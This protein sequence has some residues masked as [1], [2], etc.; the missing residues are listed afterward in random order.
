[1]A[2]RWLDSHMLDVLKGAATALPLRVLG[3]G[4]GFALNL[5]LARLLGADDV[6]IYYLALTVSTMASAVATLGLGNVLVRYTAAEAESGDYVALKA[7]ARIGTRTSL[8]CA[9]ALTVLVATAAPWICEYILGKPELTRPLQWMALTIVPQTQMRLHA[10]LLRGLKKIALSQMLRNVDVP[11]LT[12]VFIALLGGT[13]GATGAVWSFVTANLIAAVMAVWLWRRA[14]G[15]VEAG[16]SPLGLRELLRSGLPILQANLM[17]MGLTPLTTLLL[18]AMTNS[19]SVAIFA[20]AFRTSL[21]TR[22]AKMAVNAIAAPKFAAL[23]RMADSA[24]LSST[25][26]RS[27]LLVSV[28]SLPM[29]LCF[30]V[31]P[32]WT[33]GLFGPT[34]A[35]GAMLL[36]VLAIGQTA[37]VISVSVPY[38]LIMSGNER[39]LRNN[40]LVSAAV[41]LA[42]NLLLIPSYGATGAAIA[43]ASAMIV[44]SLLGAFQVY[45]SLGI[46][47]FFI[48][49]PAVAGDED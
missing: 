22:F 42:L 43:V 12:L 26:R 17:N 3:A 34:F 7:I 47:P 21:L 24:A 48:A 15:P 41:C 32:H 13:Y 20:I 39:K 37:A 38:L 5:L 11:F 25:S 8:A 40:T 6:G 29:L 45:R 19:A 23:H 2:A 14:A 4:I 16:D 44:R 49:A 35:D 33:M 9:V 28:A 46:L 30:I 18:G 36:R 1:M 27:S 10:Q 31:F